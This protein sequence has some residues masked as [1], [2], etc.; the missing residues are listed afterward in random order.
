LLAVLQ[1]ARRVKCDLL[2]RRALQ[3]VAQGRQQ[4]RHQLG[5]Q[6]AQ[7]ACKFAHTLRFGGVLGVVTQGMSVV[8]D[9]HAAA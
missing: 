4:K 7:V 3:S 5:Q 1:G 6:L 9:H 8:F 2:R